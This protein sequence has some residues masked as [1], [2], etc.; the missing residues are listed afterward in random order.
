MNKKVVL[1]TTTT[2][3][4]CLRALRKLDEKGVS[5][6]TINVREN[7]EVFK[8]IM[9]QTGSDTV[10]QIYID[11]VFI[12]GCDDLHALDREGKLNALLGI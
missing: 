8:T 3:P 11:D 10:P 4:Y 7:P 2:C 12:G 9:A 1:Y 6:E 5:Y